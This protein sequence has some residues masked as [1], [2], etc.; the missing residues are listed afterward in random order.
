M[1]SLTIPR[2]TTGQ[3]VEDDLAT[4]QAQRDKVT[5]RRVALERTAEVA[6]LMKAKED[7]KRREKEAEQQREAGEQQREAGEARVDDATAAPRALSPQV[8]EKRKSTGDDDDVSDLS[9]ASPH[10]LK[11]KRAKDIVAGRTCQP[12]DTKGRECSWDTAGSAIRA[13]KDCRGLKLEC[14]FAWE[15]NLPKWKK[16]RISPEDRRLRQLQQMYDARVRERDEL[17]RDL[18]DLLRREA[19]LETQVAA[20]ENIVELGRAKRARKIA[21]RNRK[22]A[23]AGKAAQRSGKGQ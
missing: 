8:G 22:A 16:Q 3:I 9:H 7:A 21:A 19:L 12:C 4:L 1:P 11:L 10:D 17:E 18:A 15:V 6:K 5:A 23:S 20:Y 14:T 13:C 2:L